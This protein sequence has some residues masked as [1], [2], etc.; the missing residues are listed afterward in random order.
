MSDFN[1][2]PKIKGISFGD[3]VQIYEPLHNLIDDDHDDPAD[4]PAPTALA[5]AILCVIAF[6]LVAF[7]IAIGVAFS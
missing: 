3:D 5:I 4:E 1:E 2:S 7:G 6:A